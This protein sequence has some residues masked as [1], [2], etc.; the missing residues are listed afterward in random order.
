TLTTSGVPPLL[1]GQ[2]YFLGVQNTNSV[3]VNFRL[4][5]EF[6][7]TTLLNGV[8][9]TSDLP[10]GPIPRYFQFDVSTNAAG[11][12]FQIFDSSGNVDLVV[13]PSPPLPSLAFFDYGSFNLGTNN[14]AIG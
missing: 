3:P 14:E 2:R 1:P 10:A 6:E 11:V 12:A 7:I 4:Q 13:R 5:V 9:L 8:P